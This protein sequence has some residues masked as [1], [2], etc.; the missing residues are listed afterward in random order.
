MDSSWNEPLLELK[1]PGLKVGL[2]LSKAQVRQGRKVL[3]KLD[4]F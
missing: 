3:V 2:V 4:A 1:G